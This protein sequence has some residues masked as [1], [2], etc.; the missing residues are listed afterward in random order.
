M[1]VAA[2]IVASDVT[3]T[4]EQKLELGQA[5]IPLEELIVKTEATLAYLQYALLNATGTTAV[6]S[7][8]PATSPIST[9][10]STTTT[11]TTT[12]T[13]ETEVTGKALSV[14]ELATSKTI[15]NDFFLL[16]SFVLSFV[17][18]LLL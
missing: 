7:T 6:F 5:L 14:L 15:M 18:D 12:T 13:P 2:N 4:E 3:C 16:L 9:N 1:T 17:N 8:I 10:P 11:T